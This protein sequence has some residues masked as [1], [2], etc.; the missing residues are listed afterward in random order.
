MEL[1]K[2]TAI[3]QQVD[4]LHILN[5]VERLKR[6]KIH[7]HSFLL[8]RHDKVIAQG[9][10]SP[11]RT[12]CRHML[13]SLSKS[14]TSM[15]AGFAVQEGLLSVEDK[16]LSF[17]PDVLK[18]RPCE[19][20]EK[21]RVKHLL[22]MN[23]G[24]D[25]EPFFLLP[26]RE[27]DWAYEFLTSYVA[28]EPGTHFLYNTTATYMLSVI[29]TKVTGEKV[30]DY[31]KPRLFEPLG[32]DRDIWWE[33]SP[34]GYTA[35][36]VGLNLSAEDIARFGLFLLHKGNVDGVQLLRKEWF[37]EAVYPWSDNSS[38]DQPDWKQGY[39]YQLWRCVPDKAYRAD[40]AFGQYCVVCPEQ[41]LVLALT[42]G[43]PQMQRVLTAL[44]EEILYRLDEPADS[45]KAEI[46]QGRL[47][48]ELKS[49]VLPAYFEEEGKGE[50]I[51]I[52]EYILG[53]KYTLSPNQFHIESLRFERL[54]EGYGI[55]LQ[56]GGNTSTFCLSDK[57]WTKGE[58]NLQSDK[59]LTREKAW[60]LHHGLFE[61]IS[62]KGT[63]CEDGLCFDMIFTETPFCDTWNISWHKDWISLHIKR[64]QSF[65]EV[66][67]QAFGVLCN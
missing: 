45:G 5:F 38:N 9:G 10:F 59:L 33:E 41:K 32:F 2:S 26:Q 50:E 29:I 58:L 12:D 47:E 62:V 66:E 61:K 48:E 60:V 18:G 34:Q 49:L 21:M 8:L 3:E 15:A 64:D 28:F 25:R 39:G 20:M 67:I 7:I 46:L 24:H 52:P 27:Y 17:F 57:E 63:S 36:G 55:S 16:V 19:N 11:Y 53:R 4:P 35:G 37:E 14:F 65:M 13:F 23:T 40:G 42:G 30:F 51:T 1:L 54:E 56:I 44:W 31:L 6:E 43:Y 22:T